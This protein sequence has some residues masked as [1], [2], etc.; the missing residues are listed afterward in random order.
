M[1]HYSLFITY[2]DPDLGISNIVI[3][4]TQCNKTIADEGSCIRLVKL[5]DMCVLNL[6]V[7]FILLGN[8]YVLKTIRWSINVNIQVRPQQPI[9]QRTRLIGSGQSN[10][11]DMYLNQ[12]IVLSHILSPF[13]AATICYA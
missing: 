2:P 8:L 13:M 9:G 1:A 10:L 5:R 7:N 4:K 3:V 6:D 12:R 11:L